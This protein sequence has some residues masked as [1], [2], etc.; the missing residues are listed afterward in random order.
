M[1]MDLL[2][3]N[4]FMKTKNIKKVVETPTYNYTTILY[5]IGGAVSLFLGISITMLF[6]VLEL[7]ADMVINLAKYSY[8]PS[9]DK[10]TKKN[11][12]GRKKH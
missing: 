9:T 6:E 8:N 2:K 5:A 11:A 1:K 10:K 7:F 12:K 4:V 3:V